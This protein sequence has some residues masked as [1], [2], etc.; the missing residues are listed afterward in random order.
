MVLDQLTINELYT[1]IAEPPEQF[2]SNI[3]ISNKKLDAL[4]VKPDTNKEIPDKDSPGDLSRKS[5]LIIHGY[6]ETFPIP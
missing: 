2:E 1:E 6:S 3:N 5:R 4:Y